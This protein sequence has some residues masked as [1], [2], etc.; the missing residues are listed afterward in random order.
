MNHSLQLSEDNL[1]PSQIIDEET[2]FKT[3]IEFTEIIDGDCLTRLYKKLTFGY[4]AQTIISIISNILNIFLLSLPY[5]VHA[6]GLCFGSIILVYVF[7]TSYFALCRI[8]DVLLKTNALSFHQALYNYVS[9]NMAMFYNIIYVI[10]LF[11][12]LLLYQYLTFTIVFRIVCNLFSIDVNTSKTSQLIVFIV[13][14]VVQIIISQ[15]SFIYTKRALFQ[16]ITLFTCVV[17][18]IVRVILMILNIIDASTPINND[19][20]DDSSNDSNIWFKLN[21][22]SFFSYAICVCIFCNV[23]NYIFP[24]YTYF[25]LKSQK[26]IKDVLCKSQT[27]SIIAAFIFCVVIYLSLNVTYDNDEMIILLNTP[28]D[29]RILT[30]IF[31][32]LFCILILTYIATVLENFRYVIRQTITNS[33]HLTRQ[34]Q[35]QQNGLSSLLVNIFVLGISTVI[36]GIMFEKERLFE[37]LV[38]LI[39]GIC[40]GFLA[41]VFPSVLYGMVVD[42]NCI[43]KVIASVIMLVNGVLGII[44]FIY[45]VIR[46]NTRSAPTDDNDDDSL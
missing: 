41:F 1:L 14:F 25:E 37:M 8:L 10:Y 9:K 15:I 30:L 2:E 39:G 21:T 17:V 34:Q 24:I 31:R 27:I 36:V 18:F 33:P 12:K 42:G 45:G 44:V 5:I 16:L 11:G 7:I 46:F 20:D 35:Q 29:K 22:N 32:V 19:N 23:H 40:L 4:T 26:R 38:C 3:S 13:L 28:N 43:R 6:N